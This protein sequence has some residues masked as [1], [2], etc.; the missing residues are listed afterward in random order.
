MAENCGNH[1]NEE[2]LYVEAPLLLLLELDQHGGDIVDDWT[3]LPTYHILI[4]QLI[5]NIEDKCNGDN[6]VLCSVSVCETEWSSWGWV[7]LD[8]VK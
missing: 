6:I 5:I 4:N 8:G 2:Y 1:D 3:L 7:V